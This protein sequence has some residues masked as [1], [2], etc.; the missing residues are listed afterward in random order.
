MSNTNKVKIIN[1]DISN[2][3]KVIV[4][5]IETISLKEI[6][7]HKKVSILYYPIKIGD[8][9]KGKIYPQIR[10]DNKIQINLYTNIEA[11][12]YQ[13]NKEM[14]LL[15]IKRKDWSYLAGY[16]INDYNEIV[17]ITSINQLNINN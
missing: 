11:Y 4:T 16:Y 3:P 5:N 12:M 9:S 15:L 1:K 7:I 14:Y 17:E 10:S 8:Y 6:D 2:S 13:Y